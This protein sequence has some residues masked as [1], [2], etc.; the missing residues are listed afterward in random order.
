MFVG[1]RSTRIRPSSGYR[2]MGLFD[3]DHPV[4]EEAGKDCVCLVF[5]SEYLSCLSIVMGRGLWS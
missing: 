1:G 5:L 4:G 3:L 2:A